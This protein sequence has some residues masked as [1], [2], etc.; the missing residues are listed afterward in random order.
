MAK[1][2]INWPSTI[3][4]YLTKVEDA[5]DDVLKV[6]HGVE[7][8]ANSPEGQAIIRLLNS[9]RSLNAVPE[10]HTLGDEPDAP[11]E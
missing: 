5:V 9:L 8:F 3:K 7:D 2:T 1:A 6:V 4:T 10:H 11:T